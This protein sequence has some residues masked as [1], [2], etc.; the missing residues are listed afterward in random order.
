V[1]YS[2]F[3][4]PSTSKELSV[5][6]P[7]GPVLGGGFALHNTAGSPSG[8]AKLRAV[9]SYPVDQDTWLVRASS[10]QT[11]CPFNRHSPRRRAAATARP[12]WLRA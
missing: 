11:V 7:N 5:H 1:V 6:C 2:G 4:R 10:L 9:R 12:A 8:Q 3:L